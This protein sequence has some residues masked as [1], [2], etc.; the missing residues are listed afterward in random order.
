MSLQRST[1]GD[2]YGQGSLALLSRFLLK[3]LLVELLEVLE[4]IGANDSDRKQ[5]MQTNK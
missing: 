4:V 2:Q 5:V 1:T 3:V